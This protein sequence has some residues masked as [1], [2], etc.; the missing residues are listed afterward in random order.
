MDSPK[1]GEHLAVSLTSRC[2][3]RCDHCI[4]ESGPE[5]H[6]HTDLG[7]D[8]VSR[9]LESLRSMPT[10]PWLVTFTGGE[11]ALFPSIL[12]DATEQLSAMG[13]RS[14]LMTSGYWAKSKQAAIRF[15]GRL[16]PLDHITISTD[17]EHLR[18]VPFQWV[19]NAV[20]ASQECSIDV[21]VR[22]TIAED[23]N[24]EDSKIVASCKAAFGDLV[25]I[26][27][28]VPWGRAKN[29]DRAQKQVTA[30]QTRIQTLPCPSDGAHVLESGDVIPCCSTIVASPL[31]HSLCLGNIHNES[32][33]NIAER[34]DSN[35]LLLYI[36]LFGFGPIIDA[37]NNVGIPAENTD[38]NPC[39]FCAEFLE[40][41]P[42]SVF[43][44]K[45]VRSRLNIA[46]ICAALK[47]ADSSR[48]DF[49]AIIRHA[50]N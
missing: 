19:V 36:R 37:A 49:S 9:F 45:W 18:F 29:F 35:P 28:F 47:A 46:K 48:V 21:G 26:K 2:P 20:E 38:P 44:E 22:V 15:I 50:A 12:R 33:S 32:Y 30:G 39:H 23:V 43:A 25:D 24:E 10:K 4:S 3:L 8:V 41:K 17:T 27:H 13:V 42:L 16:G 14:A 6:L 40:D 34:A 5:K 7:A 11:A 31:Q 1:F